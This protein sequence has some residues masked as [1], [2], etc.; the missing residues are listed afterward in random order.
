MKI[1]NFNSEIEKQEYFFSLER[2]TQKHTLSMLLSFMF[3][4]VVVGLSF[5]FS[6]IPILFQ[7]LLIVVSVIPSLF[8]TL[9]LVREEMLMKKI[10]LTKVKDSDYEEKK[11]EIDL[12]INSVDSL[13][14]EASQLL[15][16]NPNIEFQE[17]YK[18]MLAKVKSKISELENLE[19]Q[20]EHLTRV[21]YALSNY[22]MRL[23]RLLENPY[24]KS[25]YDM[26][27][28]KS[29]QERY[30][31]MIKILNSKLYLYA[32]RSY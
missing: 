23:S 6:S 9:T 10:T 7:V 17:E 30:E 20:G 31:K 32:N 3:T 1:I 29:G 5:A 28:F 16:L 14:L 22:L 26:V 19:T 15:N 2:K 27:M 24:S 12:A 13:V 11:N 8:Y 25:G 21:K 4:T 18:E